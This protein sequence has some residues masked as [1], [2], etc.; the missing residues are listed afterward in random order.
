M[1]CEFLQERNTAVCEH[2]QLSSIKPATGRGLSIL[3]SDTT[4]ADTYGSGNVGQTLGS[5]IQLVILDTERI[6]LLGVL[7]QVLYIEWRNH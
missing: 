1:V 3:I 4:E 6:E 2:T 5:V 7:E